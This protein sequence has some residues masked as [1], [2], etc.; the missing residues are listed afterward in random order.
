MV[1]LLYP[2]PVKSAYAK[3]DQQQQHTRQD[4]MPIYG[5][6]LRARR[7]ALNMSQADVAK[8]IGIKSYQQYDDWERE[9]ATP[10]IKHLPKLALVLNGSIDYF[11]GLV[12]DPGAHLEEKDLTPDEVELLRRRRE[13]PIFREVTDML[14]RGFSLRRIQQPSRPL[15]ESGE[16]PDVS[17]P[18][19][20]SQ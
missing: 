11:L 4:W 9:R 18:D 12:D 5:D 10:P 6:R 15:I 8:A 1:N 13:D 16:K 17:G 3:T 20:S 19:E 2:N 14:L 7:L